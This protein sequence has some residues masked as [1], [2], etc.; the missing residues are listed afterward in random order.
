MLEF[1]KLLK[2]VRVIKPYLELS[3]ISF[4]DISLGVKY[5]W[6]DEF[7]VE[8]AIYND[9]LILKE[10]GHDHAD[11][12]YYPMGAD[13][14]GAL[15]QI[16]K[17]CLTNFMPL[18]FCYIDDFYVQK[19]CSRYYG[20]KVRCER[21]WCDYI[22][23]AEQFKSYAGKKLSGQRN[24]VNKFQ[25]LYPDYKFKK[26]VKSDL[27]RVK[28]FLIEYES[29]RNIIGWTEKVEEKTALELIENAE[30][31]NQVCGLLEVGEK[32]IAISVGEIVNDTLIVHIEKA[33][34]DY[35]GVY[36]VMAKEF[37]KAFAIDGVRYINREEDCGDLGL[38]TSK[39]QYKPCLIKCKHI[40]EIGTLFDKIKSPI[41]IKTERLEIAEIER[42]DSEEYK[43]LYLD[44]NVNKLW[45]YDYREDLGCNEPTSEYFY[46][47]QKLLKERKEEFSF[48]IKLCGELIGEL[49]LHNFD[50]Y[51][52]V[53][54]GFRFFKQYQGKGYAIESASALKDYVFKVLGAKTLKSRC[55]KENFNSAK[56]I[57][58]L[59]L[60]KVREDDTHFYFELKI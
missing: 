13:E 15:E 8:Y 1:K 59:G 56:L 39:L 11:A 34:K 25:K 49:V 14:N 16:E 4:C 55:Y 45:G 7:K 6:R 3:P 60:I 19:L 2:D 43:K 44:E 5:A 48:A 36:P 58:R 46:N 53:E 23:F 52:G 32:V 30:E 40:I 42:T 24:H 50:F 31:L 38:R 26:I 18:T 29:G 12:F 28:A 21:D 51:G 9:T 54:M 57:G 20:A 27:E 10:S 33:L 47:F 17:Y 35:Q 41:N 22:Y 37:A